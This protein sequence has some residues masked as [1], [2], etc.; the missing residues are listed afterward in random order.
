MEMQLMKLLH[1][2]MKEKSHAKGKKPAVNIESH[3][4]H[5]KKLT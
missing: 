3:T 2:K 5:Q 1:F 4:E